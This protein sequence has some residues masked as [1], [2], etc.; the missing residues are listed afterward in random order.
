MAFQNHTS[1]IPLARPLLFEDPDDPTHETYSNAQDR[2]FLDPATQ[3]AYDQAVLTAAGIYNGDIKEFTGGA[4]AFL[5]P[6]GLQA[7]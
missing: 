7:A 6:T 5:S 1:G 2:N 4:F 3:L